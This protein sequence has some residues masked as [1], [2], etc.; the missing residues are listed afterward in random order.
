MKELYEI[1]EEAYPFKNGNA[2]AYDQDV[3]VNHD[4]YH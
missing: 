1:N 4:N 2:Y 3:E